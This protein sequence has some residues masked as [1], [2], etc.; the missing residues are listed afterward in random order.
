MFGV[1]VGGGASLTLADSVVAQIGDFPLQGC[2]SGIAV[3][4][5]G[6]TARITG[7]TVTGSGPTPTIAQNG[8][9]ISFGATGSVTGSTITGSNYTGTPQQEGYYPTYATGILVYGG[10]GTVCGIG[11]LA[12]RPQGQL[13]R[14]HTDEPT[15]RATKLRRSTSSATRPA[16]RI[17]AT[18]M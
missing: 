6:S 9:Q 5:P 18:G 17:P 13:D 2:Q 16:L 10:G 15:S 4:G 14:Q 11:R 12:A 8:I 3:D 7:T 1:L